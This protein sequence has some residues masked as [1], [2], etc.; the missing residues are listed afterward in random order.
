MSYEQQP[1]ILSNVFP[2]Q[3]WFP[4]QSGAPCSQ[5]DHKS[6]GPRKFRRVCWCQWEY[7]IKLQNNINNRATDEAAIIVKRLSG[8]QEDAIVSGN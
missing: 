7:I 6:V 1:Y 3:F 2:T 4:L 8:E 5:I